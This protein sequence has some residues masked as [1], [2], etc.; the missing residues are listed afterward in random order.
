LKACTTYGVIQKPLVAV[1]PEAHTPRNGLRSVARVEQLS[2][3]LIA[4]NLQ[5]AAAVNLSTAANLSTMETGC[6]QACSSSYVA[7]AAT[8]SLQKPWHIQMLANIQRPEQSCNPRT[9]MFSSRS[10]LRTFF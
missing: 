10:F 2:G 8:T 9:M 7:S 3:A 1:S 4:Q 5:A 6:S